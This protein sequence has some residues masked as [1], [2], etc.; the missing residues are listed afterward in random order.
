MNK[1]LSLAILLCV[2]ILFS[3]CLGKIF[4]VGENQT[5]YEEIGCDYQDAGVVDS[6]YKIMKNKKAT[7]KEAYHDY[8]CFR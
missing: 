7:Q 3:G 2:S 4:N 5:R 1:V 8:P 6:P